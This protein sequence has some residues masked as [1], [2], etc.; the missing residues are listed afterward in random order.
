MDEP[1]TTQPNHTMS[2]IVKLSSE[3][4]KRLVAVEITPQGN[5]VVVGGANG[6][7]KSSVLDSIEFALG[8]DPSAKM[9]VRRGE[10]KARIVVD[11][12]DIVVRRTFTAAGGTS[13]VVTNADGAKQATPQ[14]LLD[15]LV[16]RLTFD[17]LAFS[18]ERPKEQAEI[19]RGLVGLDFAAHD[20]E[21]E[22]VFEERTTINREAKELQARIAGIPK[23]EGLPEKE[24][25]TA[26]ILAEQEKAAAKNAEH[27]ELRRKANVDESES[28]R[29]A[30]DADRAN[31]DVKQ[32]EA[33]IK[34]LQ[35]LLVTRQSVAKQADQ[36]LSAA[37]KAATKSAAAA[38][39]LQDI[40]LRQFQDR[41]AS[42]EEVNRKVRQAKQRA[43]LVTQLRAKTEAAEKLTD[44]L[45]KLDG[46]K[47][48]A[49]MDAKYP[50]EGLAF[51]TAGGV[52]FNG[53]P[54]DQCSSAEQLKVSVAVGIAL[55]PKLK[56]LLCR[57]GSLLDPDSF[58]VLA[59]MA[60][61]N[62]VQIWLER[63]GEDATTS[64]VIEDGHVK[65]DASTQKP[66]EERLPGQLL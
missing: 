3:N 22:K 26:D 27:S 48:K 45:D 47:R 55:N 6:A 14:A 59:K 53:I 58:A 56:V 28:L 62:A 54:F 63:V 19:L 36:I 37:N 15:K 18:R 44:Q 31:Q 5:V 65:G 10:E 66:V 30:K 9:P 42:V 8:G 1:E 60:K 12:G 41:A 38:R 7:G 29:A 20:A 51:D 64:V 16:G 49:A 24:E 35:A 61:D 23:H 11:L 39:D 33:E 57:D 34:R 52:T 25:S 2:K 4:V 17:P 21:R 46:T 50:V 13:L 43:E 40:D 32:T